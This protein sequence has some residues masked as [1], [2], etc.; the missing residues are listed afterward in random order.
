[1]QIHITHTL[2]G[3]EVWDAKNDKLLIFVD[4]QDDPIQT[5]IELLK[6]LNVPFIEE[7]PL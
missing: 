2:G 3:I 1:M 5:T 4:R 6:L 7:A